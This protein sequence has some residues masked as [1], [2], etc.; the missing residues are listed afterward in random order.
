M[1]DFSLYWTIIPVLV[2]LTFK[3]VLFIWPKFWLLETIFLPPPPPPPPPMTTYFAFSGLAISLLMKY[4]CVMIFVFGR[5]SDKG[6]GTIITLLIN[7][8]VYTSVLVWQRASTSYSLCCILQLW[9]HLW[10]SWESTA[11]MVHHRKLC[12]SYLAL[13]IRL[14]NLLLQL[15]IFTILAIPKSCIRSPSCQ[16]LLL[17]IPVGL[18]TQWTEPE[19]LS[20]LSCGHPN[21]S[22]HI[23]TAN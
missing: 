6:Q 11:S 12:N 16:L 14:Y 3:G 2:T 9:K 5:L 17:S 8:V 1:H 15:H 21:D 4:L 22:D 10:R 7:H 19:N 23:K 20:Q 18:H 13:G